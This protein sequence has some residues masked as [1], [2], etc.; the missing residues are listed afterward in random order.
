MAASTRNMGR[1]IAPRRRAP[2][3]G[4]EIERQLAAAVAEGRRIRVEITA[5]IDRVFGRARGTR[6]GGQHR[7]WRRVIGRDVPAARIRR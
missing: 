5:R 3:Q 4:P 7:R 2:V 6:C 1:R